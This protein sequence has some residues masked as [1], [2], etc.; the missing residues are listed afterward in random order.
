MIVSARRFSLVPKD[1]FVDSDIANMSYSLT[2][3]NSQ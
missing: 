3:V 2:R 1:A